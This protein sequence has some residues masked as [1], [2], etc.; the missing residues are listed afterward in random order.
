MPFMPRLR[1]TLL[2]AGTAG[3]VLFTEIVLTRLFSV[4]LFYH[5]S[6]L[7][8][9]LALFG[10]AV[11]GLIAAR[12]PSGRDVGRFERRVRGRL[13]GACAALLG[14]AELLAF[15]PPHGGDPWVAIGLALLSAIPLALMGEVLARA[16]AQGRSEIHRLYALDLVSS[17]AAALAAI[18]LLQYVQGPLALGIP[19]LACLALATI[20]SG[21]ARPLLAAG[22]AA[23][24]ALLVVAAVRPGPVFPLADEWIGRPML[25]RW[26]AHSRVRVSESS[27]GSREL[28]I[29]R[30][31]Q[32]AIPHVPPAGSGP[33]P[34]DSTWAWRYPDPS[35]HLGRP[36]SGV[37]IIGVGGGPDILPALA[38]GARHVVGFELNGRIV[39]LL[40][41]TLLDFN[42]ITLRPEVRLVHDEARHALQHRTERY[43]VIRASLI[44]TWASTAAGGFVLSE[45]ALY[46]VEAWRLF[47][48]RLTPSG[49]LA[50]TRWYLPAAPAEAERLIALAAQALEDEGLSPAA[51]RIV[52]L[53]S[54]ARIH[55]P[56][57]GGRVYV[58]TALVSRSPFAASELDSL[59][60]YARGVGGTLLL[61]PR[62]PAAPAAR[63]WPALLTPESRADLI[64]S[65]R[66]AIDPP[67]DTKPFFFLQLRPADVL[68]FQARL[69]PVSTITVNG[70]QVLVFTVLLALLGAASLLWQT[71]RLP[72]SAEAAGTESGRLGVPGRVYFAL[73]G[74]GYMAIQLALLQRLSILLGHPT[75]TLAL[76]VASMLL[77]T[78]VGS[79]LAGHGRLRQAPRVVLCLPL[80]AVVLLAV[81]FPLVGNFSGAATLGLTALGAG[82]LSGTMGLALG[83]ALPTGMNLFASSERALAE[84]WA[85][86]GAFSVLGSA[87]GAL[88]GLMVGSRWL[89]ALALSC[90][91]PVW[92]LT[93]RAT[94][95]PSASKIAFGFSSGPTQ[96]ERSL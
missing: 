6:F 15:V 40:S 57:A 22:G 33:P 52:A 19:A 42:A 72:A 76:V 84:A 24:L 70:V 79:A 8:V 27:P 2:V 34:I 56:L 1:L 82:A 10:L 59:E 45:N 49:I 63:A 81:G 30:T 64:R 38:A 69:G 62:R 74:L 46:T 89:A 96:T 94:R 48:Q 26:N 32:S 13:L 65:S 39:E 61:A 55:D 21:K 88:A 91:G 20:V 50:I 83:V 44:D 53:A 18:P 68:S 25:E 67:R 78:G 95:Q 36:V 23:L 14:I 17:A 12:Q 77:G 16:L 29:D 90:Y 86:N 51:D 47:L 41:S 37:A 92:L 11:G 71:S 87:L 75:A 5:Y 93:W 73:L 9:G 7:A 60:R 3:A 54:P 31:A 35:Y 43:D 58:I 4:L 66:W 80:L 85:I 28:I